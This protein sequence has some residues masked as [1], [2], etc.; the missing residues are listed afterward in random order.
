MR[1]ATGS[2]NTALLVFTIIGLIAFVITVFVAFFS[3][4]FI[5]D[6]QEIIIFRNFL[7]ITGVSVS[8]IFIMRTFNGILEAHLPL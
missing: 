6:P 4:I 1:N 5:H 8:L 2:I 7:L 3:K